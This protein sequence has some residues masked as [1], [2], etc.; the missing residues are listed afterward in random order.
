MDYHQWV[1]SQQC[2]SDWFPQQKVR[3]GFVLFEFFVYLFFGV[4]DGTRALYFL[5]EC[6][7]TQ[8]HP[9]PLNYNF[10]SCSICFYSIIFSTSWGLWFGSSLSLICF[11]YK[12]EKSRADT[13]AVHVPYRTTKIQAWGKAGG[14]SPSFTD[15]VSKVQKVKWLGSSL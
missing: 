9:Q 1:L 12:M 5:G 14:P 6:S 4:M 13:L 8:L 11:F 2:G 15:E 3:Y 7:T 10:D